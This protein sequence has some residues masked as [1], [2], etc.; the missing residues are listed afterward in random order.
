MQGKPLCFII[1]PFGKKR[2]PNTGFEI[3]FDSIY[4]TSV[5]QAVE[6][7]GME[8][9]RADEERTGGI[10]HKAMFERLLLSD[11]A[12]ADLTTHNA[13]VFYELGVRHAVR[14]HTTLTMYSD[15]QSVPFDLNLV[16][17]LPYNLGPTMQ[18]EKT[19]AEKLRRS[20]ANRLVELRE[21]VN[22][23]AATDS[24]LFQLL[25]GYGPPDIARLKTDVFRDRVDYELNSKRR[26]AE[27]RCAKDRSAL[28]AI[29]ANLGPLDEAEAGVIVDLL[30]SYRALEAWPAMIA[31]Y[32]R[33]P[34]T[35]RN[36]VLVREQYGFALNR[37]GQHDTA[38]DVLAELIEEYGPNSETC[39]L[40]GR[41]YKDLWS[42]TD[43]SFEAR[44]FLKRSI[45]AYQQ[46]FETDWRDAYPG[47]NAITL[48]ELQGDDDAIAAQRKL[49]PVVRYAVERR[50]SSGEP[51]YWDYATLLEL[52]VL[53][54]REE[55]AYEALADAKARIRESW[56]P[57][58]TVNNLKMIQ[59]RR[60]ALGR[61]TTW[62]QTI[63]S[64]LEFRSRETYAGET[65]N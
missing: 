53:G 28:E 41:V 58:T 49:L 34:A 37:A 57:K 52:E 27:A 59:S 56:E 4:E 35:L 15:H 2:D 22:K 21:E 8:S 60:E 20:L 9:L 50:I 64:E 44:G 10:I 40:L 24:P 23:H 30:L 32:E 65:H 1:M 36:S 16:R 31:L 5:R 45:A 51:D 12:V 43:N 11:F 3:N 54:N 62:L 25:T 19:H 42:K 55:Q 7:A 46:G 48:L 39:G 14:P 63:I 47:I 29:E 17:A 18:F 6:E 13:N 26:L 33:M 38:R 61:A